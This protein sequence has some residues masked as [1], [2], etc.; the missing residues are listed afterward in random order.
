MGALTEVAGPAAVDQLGDVFAVHRHA[1]AHRGF[2]E[3]PC[4]ARHEAPLGDLHGK[5]ARFHPRTA[6][7]EERGAGRQR[8]VEVLDAIP[9]E[10][11]SA[12][13]G[14]VRDGAL[15]D[16]DAS[17][18][19]CR[20]R[21]AADGA[22]RTAPGARPRLGS[23]EARDVQLAVGVLDERD[24]RP[25]ERE[26]TELD[27]PAEQGPHAERESARVEPQERR[28]SELRVLTNL[29]PVQLDGRPREDHDRDGRELHWA[30]ERLRRAGRDQRLHTRG[31]Y[32]ERDRDERGD[33]HDAE[34]HENADGPPEGA[35]HRGAPQTATPS[36]SPTDARGWFRPGA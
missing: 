29:E 28:G 35:H 21:P 19:A 25:L 6:L 32:H 11:A 5:V 4:V 1:R 2:G 31:V 17:R 10:R 14:D 9:R 18:Q 33:R 22:A 34:D 12:P 26:V 23:A 30:A 3:A 15:L 20:P 36:G 27:A 24:D 16:L 8:Q 13:A 7:E